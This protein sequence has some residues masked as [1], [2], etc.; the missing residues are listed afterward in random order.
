MDYAQSRWGKKPFIATE[1]VSALQT[2][3]S[4]DM[5]SDRYAAGPHAGTGLLKNANDD[6]SCSS[7]ENCSTPWGSTMKKH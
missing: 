3:G 7:Y 1:S 2:R 6:L 4:Y 5:P